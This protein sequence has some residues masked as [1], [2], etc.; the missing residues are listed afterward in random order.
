M[1]FRPFPSLFRAGVAAA[2]CALLCGQAAAAPAALPDIRMAPEGTEYMCGG[3]GRDEQA[4]MEMVSPRWGATLE[5]AV[6]RG[7]RGQ[8]DEPV[9]VR[10]VNKYNGEQVLDATA[11]GPYMLARLGPGT[12]DVQATLGTLTLTQTLNVALGAPGRM[13]FLWPSNFD[14]AAA[15]HPP[16]ALAQSQSAR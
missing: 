7:P 3:V 9:A 4:F 14:I 8:F 13:L 1:S 10:V 6:S 12:Y 15:T 5:F 2:A 11:H 16:Q